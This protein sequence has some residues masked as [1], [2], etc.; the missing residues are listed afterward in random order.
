MKGNC[1][2]AIP[3]HLY[4]GRTCQQARQAIGQIIWNTFMKCEQQAY[5]IR[6]KNKTNNCYQHLCEKCE[7]KRG[8]LSQYY[9]VR[10]IFFF[11]HVSVCVCIFRLFDRHISHKKIRDRN[12]TLYTNKTIAPPVATTTTT[13]VANPTTLS[14]VNTILYIYRK[15]S[16]LCSNWIYKS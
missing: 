7:N 1:S 6:S 12:L 16:T 13:T 15:L 10:K 11:V 8:N 5:R 3:L 9:T 2:L 4:V 14:T